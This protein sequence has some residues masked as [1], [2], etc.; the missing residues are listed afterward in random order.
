[1]NVGKTAAKEVPE[2]APTHTSKV[3]ARARVR[4]RVRVRVRIR[5]SSRVEGVM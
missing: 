5:L 2:E 4:V 3:R 1:M